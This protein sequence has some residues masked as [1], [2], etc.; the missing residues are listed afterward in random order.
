MLPT[1]A[2]L[3]LSE[4]MEEILRHPEP[5][6]AFAISGGGATGAYGAGAIDAWMQRVARDFPARSRALTPA[7]ILGSS[8]GA[9]NATT[10]LVQALKLDAGIDYGL[11]TWKAICP[12]AAPLVVGRP[13]SML[14]DL[15][16]RWVKLPRWMVFIAAAVAIAILG[17]LALAA[18]APVAV[19]AAVVIVLAAVLFHRSAF[20]NAA[21]TRT[22]ANVLRAPRAISRRDLLA[23]TDPRKIGN[24]IVA[25]WWAAAPG[26][27]P[28]FIVTTTDLSD[29]DDNLFTLV[30]PAV[31]GRLAERGWQVAQCAVDA[32]K[33]NAYPRASDSC[34]WVAADELVRCIVASTSIPGVFPSQRIALHALGSG[35]RVEHDFVDGGVLN[36]SPI[37]IAI[38]AG[39]TH[40]ISLELEPL[41]YPGPFRFVAEGG[42]PGLG[43]NVVETFETL[44]AHSTGLGIQN[45]SAW[46]RE[47]DRQGEVPDKRL[48]PIYR[49]A[50]RRRELGLLDFDGHYESALAPADPTLR[51][52]AEK[53]ASDTD[54]G[55]LFW[56][57]TFQAYPPPP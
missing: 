57:A 45:A 19:A 34:G 46:N 16:T 13:R 3:T 54:A 22:L 17:A 8:A 55:R 27:R 26:E 21:L 56:R 40:V 50:P 43:R 31:Y 52:W 29:Q 35:D 30:E 25:A 48:V 47:I 33:M 6:V 42:E 14:V 20:P 38:D 41:S 36:N 10:L 49:A 28:N 23:A 4:V 5:R 7:F 44:L 51:Q 39:A 53:G 15:A 1:G 9:L 32:A 18:P 24:D 11:D 12:R 37:H 2:W